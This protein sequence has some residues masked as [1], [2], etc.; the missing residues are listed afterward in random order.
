MSAGAQ[1]GAMVAAVLL[2]AALCAWLLVR[3]GPLPEAPPPSPAAAE[4]APERPA[5]ARSRPSG[6]PATSQPVVKS[7]PV[8]DS[9]GAAAAAETGTVRCA[10]ELPDLPLVALRSVESAPPQPGARAVGSVIGGELQ[11]EVPVGSGSGVLAVPQQVDVDV[12]WSG[13]SAGGAAACTATVARSYAVVFGTVRG[14][15]GVGRGQVTGCGGHSPVEPDGSFFLTAVAE[16]CEL[17]VV[18]RHGGMIAHGE[19]RALSPAPGVDDEVVLTAPELGALRPLDDEEI[20]MAE[21]VVEMMDRMVGDLSADP[22]IVDA[23]RRQLEE[24]LAARAAS[25]GEELP[26]PAEGEP[27]DTAVP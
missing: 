24:A 1:R 14:W 7:R 4:P 15:E 16:P 20:E 22:A 21:L 10:V 17:H 27:T 23:Q 2:V 13:V 8:E 3:P 5:G 6:M 9:G 18:V 19:P 11:L 12:T 25:G 26:P